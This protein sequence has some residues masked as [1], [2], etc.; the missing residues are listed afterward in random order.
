MTKK[1]YYYGEK[2]LEGLRQ[3]A[4]IIDYGV[5]LMVASAINEMYV[6]HSY[7]ADRKDVF[8]GI[9]K[10]YCNNAFREARQHFS[11]IS[12]NMRCRQFWL[13]YSDKVVDEAE[14]DITLF[15]ISIKQTLDKANHKDSEL[16]SHI[17][18]ARVLIDMS[19]VQFKAVIEQQKEKYGRNYSKEFS[20]YNLD[21]VLK[22]WSDMCQEFYRGADVDLNTDDTMGMF[23]KMVKRFVDGDYIQACFTEAANNNPEFIRNE[24]EIVEERQR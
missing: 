23:D 7:L 21:S 5:G 2:D 1:V 24:I 17:E 14:D 22:W 4:R 16:I 12:G 20:E 13:D 6:A 10:H 9:A 19:I 15:R 11:M 18:T 8:R 3:T